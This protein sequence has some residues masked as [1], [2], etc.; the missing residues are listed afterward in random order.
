[1]TIATVAL[2]CLFVVAYSLISRKI[3]DR[4]VSGPMIFLVFGLV[5]GPDG[6]DAASFDIESSVVV[7]LAELTL[8]VVLFSDAARLDV[9]ALRRDPGI[10]ARLL[11]IG[12]PLTVAL[13][14]GMT[15]LLLTDLSWAE[16]ALVAAV[17]TPTD[18][19]LGQ[20]V[21]TDQR[22]PLRIRQ[23]LNVE[24]GL[25]DGLIVPVVLVFVATVE[26]E[27]LGGVDEFLAD[28][29][30]EMLIGA[31]VGVG[32]ALV[33]GWL[34]STADR[35]GWVAKDYEQLAMLAIGVGAYALSTELDG[36]GFMAAFLAGITLS[37]T[38]G[39]EAARR[40]AFSEDLAQLLALVMFVVFGAIMVGPA[41]GELTVPI[42]VC[43]LATLT[44][45][46]MLPVWFATIGTG[47]APVSRLFLG[48]FGPR[49]LASIL[50][51]LL[52]VEESDIATKSTL[53]VIITW[54]VVAS[55]F[56]HGVTAA[57]GAARYSARLEARDD[58]EEMME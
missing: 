28:A 37:H 16:A 17:L 29:L 47:L 2:L 9:P 44:L 43:A 23:S 56:A 11:A 18:A 27:E 46:R 40:V 6:L 55:V 36:N 14:T 45:G 34:L 57:P 19:A 4:A 21:V 30:S 52:I 31:G 58:T 5:I 51:G 26:G 10:P 38:M 49:G 48:W 50:F 53:F 12:L 8:A 32:L 42:A 22:V 41:L 54:V 7:V 20:A 15:A 1:M 24:S 39:A 13:G 35:N 33:A 3:E 25:N